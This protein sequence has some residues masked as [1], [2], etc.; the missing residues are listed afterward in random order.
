MPVPVTQPWNQPRS[1]SVTKNVSV[2]RPDFDKIVCESTESVSSSLDDNT[3]QG[4][5]EICLLTESST[6]TAQTAQCNVPVAAS[7]SIG[8]APCSK[9]LKTVPKKSAYARKFLDKWTTQFKWLRYDKNKNAAFCVLC[10][11]AVQKSLVSADDNE[12]PFVNCTTMLPEE[13]NVGFQNWKK[14]IERFRLHESSSMHR[15]AVFKLSCMQTGVN[16]IIKHSK[17]ARNVTSPVS[18]VEIILV[19]SLSCHSG[20]CS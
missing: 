2:S 18:F 11:D 4:A 19:T 17:K 6:A 1:L 14:A 7:S 8:K 13:S 5:S 15:E 9:T 20:P 12:S 16:S 10:T 3:D